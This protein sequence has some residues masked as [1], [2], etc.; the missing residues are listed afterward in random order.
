MEKGRS[1]CPSDMCRDGSYLD[2]VLRLLANKK[3]RGADANYNTQGG[4]E[5]EA[6]Y[7][8]Q[9]KNPPP[10]PQPEY[11]VTLL[12]PPHICYTVPRKTSVCLDIGSRGGADSGLPHFVLHTRITVFNL[13][14]ML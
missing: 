7:G 5:S 1:N 3:A 12:G 6:P 4:S 14:F 2:S 9:L 8:R 13:F 10:S 11:C